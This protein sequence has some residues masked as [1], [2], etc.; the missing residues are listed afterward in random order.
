MGKQRSPLF[1]TTTSVL[2]R[3]KNG[4]A[5]N[6]TLTMPVYLFEGQLLKRATGYSASRRVA[7]DSIT[8]RDNHVLF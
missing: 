7:G 6:T 4:N 2:S 5:R 3:A 8:F 1:I